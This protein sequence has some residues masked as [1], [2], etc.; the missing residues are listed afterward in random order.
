MK[1]YQEITLVACQ[2]ALVTVSLCVLA[3]YAG[4]SV[5]QSDQGKVNLPWVLEKTLLNNVQLQSFPYELRVS[6]ALTIQAGISPNPEFSVE[7]ENVL[8]TGERQGVDNAEIT[9][10]L[11]QL[12]ELGGK[13]Q[14]RV[15]VAQAT[16]RQKL[17]EYEILRLDILAE[18]TGRYYQLL[19]LQALQDWS[20][21][22]FL[23][24]QTALK[25]IESRANAGAVIQ[26][27]VTKMALRLSRTKAVKEQL[28]GET[29]LARLRL[30]AMWSREPHFTRALGTLDLSLTLPTAASVLNAIETAPQ[31]LQLLSV[32]RLMY[33]KRRME[34]SKAQYDV[35]LGMGVRSYE[36]FDDGALMFN[37]SMP[38][39]LSNPNQGNILAAKANEDRA[40]EQQKLVR[41]QLRL[42]LMEIHQVMVNNARQASRIQQQVL[43]LAQRLLEDTQGAYQT[44]QTNVLQLVDAQSELFAIERE[45][46]EVKVAVY[47]Q[48]LEL[49]RITGQSMTATDSNFSSNA[50]SNMTPFVA[51]ENR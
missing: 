3:L 31:Y 42:S 17:S 36:G 19:R 40:M 35:T 20:E 39:P 16:E 29:R 9:L 14:R 2:R 50:R 11:S 38:I 33:A 46:I 48:R 26:A 8:G 4:K 6:E 18:A 43:P 5:A 23:V 22:R 27:D 30:A 13:R 12:I 21:R 1:R 28:D 37:F 45:L 44:G 51:Q 47:Q 10:A 25:A 41:G 15:D 34:E 24:E 49:E 7:V 32:E